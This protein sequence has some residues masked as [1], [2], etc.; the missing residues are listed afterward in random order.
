MLPTSVLPRGIC[1]SFLSPG[2]TS[3]AFPSHCGQWEEKENRARG[4]ES[5]DLLN[6]CFLLLPE[7]VLTASWRDGKA[8]NSL[9]KEICL[10][11]GLKF[12]RGLKCCLSLYE[13]LLLARTSQEVPLLFIEFW[14]AYAYSVVICKVVCWTWAVSKWVTMTNSRTKILVTMS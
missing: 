13:W 1:L 9:S 8:A 14:P 11:A 4:M 2:I 5:N 10:K 7:P 6:S 3:F 12:P